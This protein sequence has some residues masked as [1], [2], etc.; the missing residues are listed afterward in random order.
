MAVEFREGCASVPAV[1]AVI[2]HL[3]L[4]NYGIN[5]IHGGASGNSRLLGGVDYLM[6]RGA[7][8]RHRGG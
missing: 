4:S 7:G 8:D 1:A 3:A 2:R 5:R 6:G